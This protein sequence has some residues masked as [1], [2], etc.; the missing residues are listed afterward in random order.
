MFTI[1]RLKSSKPKPYA[2]P[3]KVTICSIGSP[4]SYTTTGGQKK[5]NV[6]FG[7]ADKDSTVK[8]VLYDLLKLGSLKVMDTVILSNF[9]FKLDPEPVVVLT[10]VSR[11]M[12]TSGLNIPDQLRTEAEHLANPPPA[13]TV[14]LKKAKVSPIKTLISLKGRVTAVS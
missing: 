11:V 13:T 14:S 3:L 9:V 10:K 4:S 1:G 8:M 2:N 7:V 6:T 5:E 12:K